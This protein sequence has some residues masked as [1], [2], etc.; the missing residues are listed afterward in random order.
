MTSLFYYAIIY[1]MKILMFGDI[2]GKIGREVVIKY[3]PILKNKYKVDF[4][5]ANGENATH[6]RGLSFDHYNELINSGIDCITVGNHFFSRDENNSYFLNT[7]KLVRPLNI[8]KYSSGE[9][10]RVFKVNDID[11]RVTVLLATTFMKD[12]GQENP[13]DMID[14]FLIRNEN[15]IEIIE[16][17]GEVCSEKLAFANYV[18]GRVSCVLGTHTHIQTADEKILTKGTA[19]ISDVGM[20]GPYH[21]VIGSTVDTVMKKYMGTPVRFEVADGIG[22]VNGVIIDIDEKTGKTNKIERINIVEEE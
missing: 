10:S 18:N 5:M 7:T 19:Y 13:F 16:Y 20:C 22:Q 12:F 15:T 17:H 1:D 2:F 11:I 3:L 6:G 9:G 21:S 14:K 8:N 4:V